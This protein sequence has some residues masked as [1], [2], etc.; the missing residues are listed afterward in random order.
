MIRS[1]L[2]ALALASLTALPALGAGVQTDKPVTATVLSGWVQPDGSRV[3]ALQLTLA[4][5]WKTYWRAPGDAGIPPQFNWSGSGN[6]GGVA[7][8]WP[9]PKV[10]DQNGM[11]SIG[12][13]DRLVIPLAI[14]PQKNGKPVHLKAEMELGVCS[15]ICMPYTLNFNA[16]LADT[17][18]KPTPA[19]AAA[20]AQQP[21]TASEAGVRA[22]TC[23]IEPTS[24][25]LRIE[26]E[27]DMPTAGGP[28]VVVI[29]PGQPNIWVSEADTKRSGRNVMAVS[30]MVHVSGGPIALDRKA[31][32]ITVLGSRHAVDIT[33][34]T[35]D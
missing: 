10:F 8:H 25:G 34:C 35:S 23:R 24:D 7:I 26:A 2:S 9:T 28:E 4:P 17:S 3:A 5:G 16:V 22:A 14:A 30:E 31:I 32:R 18:A 15:D 33:G 27:I 21:F 1:T 20:L 6:L 29:E 13:T 12:Y 11:R 19:I